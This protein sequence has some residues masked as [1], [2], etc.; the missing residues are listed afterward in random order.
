M[1]V[2]VNQQIF[3]DLSAWLTQ[4]GL[5]GL[6]SFQNGKPSG[7]LWQ[8][9]VHGNDNQDSLT[10]ALE[11][12]KVFKERYGVITEMR[13]RAAKGESVSVP[14]IAQVRQ[15]EDTAASLMRQAG[16]PAWFYDSY[17]DT[18]KLMAKGISPAELEQRI[19]QGWEKVRNTDP[20]V[21]QAFSDFYGVA[22]GDQALAAFVLDPTHTLSSL[23]KASRAAYTAGYGKNMGMSIDQ[24]LAERIA[25]LPTTEAGLQQ[26][27][28][29]ASQLMGL[30]TESI[31]DTEDLTSTNAINA[32]LLGQNEDLVKLER[33][34][35]ERLVNAGGSTG[36]AAQ[37]QQ[38]VS[39]L[40]SV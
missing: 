26:G 16:M 39:G 5:G 12:T 7:W 20:A 36:G 37:T 13:A 11:Q 19:G 28:A 38:G 40:R 3:Q 34:Q 9:I 14:T 18:Q 6:F 22:Q 10:I 25:S 23:E 8:Q 33:R 24:T 1:A 27:L 32:S 21:R 30:T 15:Y 17:K 35:Q 4:A 2:S 31:T 29:Q